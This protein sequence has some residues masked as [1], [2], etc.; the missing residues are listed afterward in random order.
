[1]FI[2]EGAILEWTLPLHPTI[3]IHGREDDLV[4]IENSL[5]V[6]HR[7]SAVM[8]VHCPNDGHRLKES[9]DQMAIALERLSSI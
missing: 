5:D 2:E 7:S 1:S 3:I 6:A 4:P 9:H 8:S